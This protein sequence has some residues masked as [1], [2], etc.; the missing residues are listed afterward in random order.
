MNVLEYTTVYELKN[1]MDGYMKTQRKG[2]HEEGSQ[3]PF[4]CLYQ[5]ELQKNQPGSSQLTV[6]ND[7]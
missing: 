7:E 1:K 5:E 6:L 4:I 3:Q 2:K